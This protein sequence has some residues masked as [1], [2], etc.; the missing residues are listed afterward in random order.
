MARK[1]RLLFW[2]V[3]TKYLAR[4]VHPAQRMAELRV[5]GTT[6]RHDEDRSWIVTAAAAGFASKG[7]LYIAVGILAALA[8]VGLG[9]P[10]GARGTA[11]RLKSNPVGFVLML[12]IA[13]GLAGYSVWRIMRGITNSE[14]ENVPQRFANF[15]T[16]AVHLF[17]LYGV[18][19]VLAGWSG[20]SDDQSAEHWTARALAQPFGRWLVIA[21]GIVL[22]GRGIWHAYKA[23]ISKLDDELDEQ[24]MEPTARRVIPWVA[25]GGMLARGLVFVLGGGSL[26]SAG[27]QMDPGDA[28]GVSGIL[29]GIGEAPFGRP[30]LA[31]VAIGFM[32]YGVYQIA[33][34]R[35]RKVPTDSG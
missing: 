29:T 6:L 8:A 28:D 31:S 5:A 34:A 10:E 24:A 18:G 26:A 27:L 22:V 15:G 23:A 16:A 14:H 21:I 30:L 32:A 25:R 19:K 35:Y 20:E 17:I 33:L 4:L 3:K 9:E 2:F 7:V 11:D 1:L 13:L 12:A